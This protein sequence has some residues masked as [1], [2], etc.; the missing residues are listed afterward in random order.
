MDKSVLL[1]VDDLARMFQV[2]HRT[3]MRW[4]K[5]GLLQRVVIGGKFVRFTQSEVDD[6]I[7]RNTR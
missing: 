7:N 1:T 6:F 4:V 3:I 2:S 5:R